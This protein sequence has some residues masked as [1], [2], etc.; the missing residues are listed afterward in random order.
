MKK[1]RNIQQ[2]SLFKDKVT[3]LYRVQRKKDKTFSKWLSKDE[4]TSLIIDDV[5]VFKKEC[6][7]LSFT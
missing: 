1:L 4:A 5:K 2:Y 6:K 7:Q 3:E